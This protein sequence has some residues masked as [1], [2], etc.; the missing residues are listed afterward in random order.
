MISYSNEGLIKDEES[1]F[2]GKEVSLNEPGVYRYYIIRYYFHILEQDENTMKLK[3]AY[4][5]Y[6]ECT[7]IVK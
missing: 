7:I 4:K 3:F 5:Y 2:D 6:A 1:F